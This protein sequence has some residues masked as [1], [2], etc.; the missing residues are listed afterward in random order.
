MPPQR[1]IEQLLASS[2][3]YPDKTEDERRDIACAIANDEIETSAQ[4]PIT[5]QS[6]DDNGTTYTYITASD[7]RRT[8]LV[9][10]GATLARAETNTNNDEISDENIA[11]L[12]TTIPGYPIDIEHNTQRNVGAFTAGRN[13][14]G[15]LMVDG[16]IWADRYPDEAD[17]VI[18]GRQRLSVEAE[19]KKASCSLC[20]GEFDTPTTYCQHI[21]TV[22]ARKESRASR[23]FTGM[24]AR[25]GAITLNPAGTGT[26]FD[27]S[28][29]YFVASHASNGELVA[30]GNGELI[31]SWYDGYLSERGET[32][33][34]LP[35]SDFADPDGR[36]FPYKI[37]GRVIQAGW[38]AAWS[39]ANGGHTGE[40]DENAIKRLKRDKP[41]GIEIKEW[42]MTDE[43]IAQMRTEVQDA[44]A[45]ITSLEADLVARDA[46]I[47][48]LDGQVNTSI[49]E[50]R[51]L[52]LGASI[53]DDEW[54]KVKDDIMA[55]PASAF[56]LFASRLATGSTSGPGPIL[57]VPPGKGEHRLT[58]G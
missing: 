53:G 9:F 36:R 33:K 6:S 31:A 4:T 57:I 27:G 14:G 11:E 13:V 52:K 55:M 51:R 18:H 2:L 12:A 37:H 7:G 21:A 17:G 28:Q 39:A 24:K 32:L 26:Q 3:F 47:A 25:G 50:V 56:D 41:A 5:F 16:V 58:L 35:D 1:L 22:K 8:L 40:K 54:K 45:K 43:E 20:G 10:K 30:D 49:A 15:A 48:E 19:A 42:A 23:R 44:L 34:D 29:I 38:K 46:R